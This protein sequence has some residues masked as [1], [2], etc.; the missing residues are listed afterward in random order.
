LTIDC[1]CCDARVR[2]HA[3]AF[4]A[5]KSLSHSDSSTPAAVAA[6][7]M[8]FVTSSTNGSLSPPEM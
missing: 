8:P 5:E 1:S 2:A 7:R 3:S 6:S 4:S